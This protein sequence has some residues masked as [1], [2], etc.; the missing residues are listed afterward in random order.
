LKKNIRIAA[1]I[2][3]IVFA[4]TMGI[5]AVS[6]FATTVSEADVSATDVVSDTDHLSAYSL[7]ELKLDEYRLSML[8]PELDQSFSAA[9]TDEE[10][11]QALAAYGLTRV[12]DI[13]NYTDGYG[14]SYSHLYNGNSFGG[15]VSMF[16]IF[17][18]NNYSKFIGSYNRLNEAKLEELRKS[19]NMLGVEA[20]AT[21]RSINGSTFFYQEYTDPTSGMN[22]LALKTI[23]GGGELQIF[24]DMASPDANDIIAANEIINSV[25]FR[26]L[27][28]SNS[29]IASQGL[30]IA[31]LVACAVLLLAV[32]L[33]GYLLYRFSRFQT[34]AGSKF[35]I[36]GFDLPPRED[37]YDYDYDDDEDDDEDYEASDD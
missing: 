5:G 6:G 8:V 29:G 4:L 31:L 22:S 23:N 24:I 16:V 35:N 36:L 21:L 27:K 15:N 1:L 13:I 28:P 26:G 2:A 37:E 34:A 25:K 30:V 3:C 33:L 20:E 19:C 14:N 12:E 11:A 32:A 9:G 10:V 17:T 18:E 7:K